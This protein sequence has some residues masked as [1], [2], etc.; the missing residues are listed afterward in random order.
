MNGAVTAASGRTVPWRAASG[1]LVPWRAASRRTVPRRVA[2]GVAR[3]RPLRLER[4]MHT[5]A[6]DADFFFPDG[7]QVRHD[8]YDVNED[9]GGMDDRE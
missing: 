6:V 1:R 4:L 2:S 7:Y 5:D 8:E 3:C 9:A